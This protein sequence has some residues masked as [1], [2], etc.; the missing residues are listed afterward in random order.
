MNEEKKDKKEGNY[1][2]VFWG[3]AAFL[4][5]FAAS[6]EIVNQF[7]FPQEVKEEISEK[8][9][10]AYYCPYEGIRFTSFENFRAHYQQ[11]HKGKQLIKDPEIKEVEKPRY[12][13]IQTSFDRN[14]QKKTVLSRSH[15]DE[16]FR[17]E[18]KNAAGINYKPDGDW[19]SFTEFKKE[20]EREGGIFTDKKTGNWALKNK[21]NGY[22]GHIRD[23]S[24]LWGW[25]DTTNEQKIK[26]DPAIASGNVK[27]MAELYGADLVGITELDS[28]W[29]YSNYYERSTGDSGELSLDGAPT[30]E[31]QTNISYDYAIVMAV[32]MD[33]EII[34]TSPSWEITTETAISHS[35]IAKLSARLAEFIR[36]LGYAAVPSGNDTTQSIPLAIDAGLGQIGR[37]GLLITPEFGARQR[38]CKVYTNLPLEQDKPI[39]FGMQ[40]YCENCQKCAEACPVNAI[41]EGSFDSLDIDSEACLLSWVER[42]TRCA[43]CI[44]ECPW[45]NP[46]FERENYGYI[47]NEENSGGTN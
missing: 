12:E 15:W 16:D 7:I 45:S 23:G 18:L 21:Y 3:S 38:I 10:L 30:P 46:Q 35:E 32:E 2:P 25:S 29:I 28:K 41:D 42:G 33:W 6:S 34:K 20:E 13:D 17:E 37:H 40:E 31:S 43:N 36:G 22:E 8:E 9:E 5:G 1:K 39:D 24:G 4:A 47:S 44:K 14:N 11:Q 26:I 27:R 19:M